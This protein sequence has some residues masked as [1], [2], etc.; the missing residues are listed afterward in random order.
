MSGEPTIEDGGIKEDGLNAAKS[1]RTRKVECGIC[2]KII[3][4]RNLSRHIISVHERIKPFH[5]EKCASSFTEKK[6]LDRHIAS[7]HEVENNI[8]L[9]VSK[10]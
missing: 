4:Q 10:I 5:C 9:K 7:I 3:Y 1:Y 6:T 8:A 2:H